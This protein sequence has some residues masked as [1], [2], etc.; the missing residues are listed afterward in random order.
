MGTRQGAGRSSEERALCA[1]QPLK[2]S[3]GPAAESGADDTGHTNQCPSGHGE[4]W[5]RSVLN[6]G[7]TPTVWHLKTRNRY[8]R[9]SESHVCPP[10]QPP[11]PSST[12]RGHFSCVVGQFRSYPRTYEHLFFFH[13]FV[14]KWSTLNILFCTSLFKIKTTPSGFFKNY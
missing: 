2:M 1:V 14:N 7:C 8:V 9:S 6:A 10:S 13:F 5:A 12:H 11:G 4:A 3:P